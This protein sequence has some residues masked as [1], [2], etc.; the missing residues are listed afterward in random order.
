MVQVHRPEEQ[1]TVQAR[2][3][4]YQKEA[5]AQMFADV[6]GEVAI[7]GRDLFYLPLT[8]LQGFGCE[9]DVGLLV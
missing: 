6:F 7:P 3:L 4:G 2:I 5:Q 1:K 9:I 8:I